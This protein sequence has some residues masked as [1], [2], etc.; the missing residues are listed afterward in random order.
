M[1]FAVIEHHR[2][3][4][5]NLIDRLTNQ[6]IMLTLA[7]VYNFKYVFIIISISILLF[8]IY[9]YLSKMLYLFTN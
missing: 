9:M 1:M 6:E 5:D 7:A 2:V 8:S 4:N 3:Y